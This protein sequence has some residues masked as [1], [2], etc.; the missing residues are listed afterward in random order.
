MFLKNYI[1]INII[2]LLLYSKKKINI[3]SYAIEKNNL[4][5]N[6]VY[7][8]IFNFINLYLFKIM[9]N[10]KKLKFNIRLYVYSF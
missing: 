3:N 1:N 7:L 8:N 2:F 5:Q 10:F 6:N 9:L 4:L